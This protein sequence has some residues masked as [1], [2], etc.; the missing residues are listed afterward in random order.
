M[1]PTYVYRGLLIAVTAAV[2]VDRKITSFEVNRYSS[3]RPLILTLPTTTKLV[4]KS[5]NVF[6]FCLFL[7][8]FSPPR[9][10]VF[11]SNSIF[12]FFFFVNSFCIGT[13]RV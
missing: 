11:S 13:L 2:I 12:F 6:R 8:V 7:L 3:S 1:V 4:F 10:V 5:Q 9:L